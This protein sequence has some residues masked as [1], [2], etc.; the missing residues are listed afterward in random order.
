MRRP[1]SDFA[2]NLSEQ[3]YRKYKAISYSTIK[4]YLTR[5]PNS[6]I[7][8][9]IE[10][11]ESMA[12]GKLE[13][14]LLT[15]RS[16][17]D[18]LYFI[19]NIPSVSPKVLE[20]F[21]LAE[22][23]NIDLNNINDTNLNTLLI[24]A[25]YYN[26]YKLETKINKFKEDSSELLGIKT[27]AGNKTVVTTD[28]F[29]DAENL[30]KSITTA[31]FADIY[32][33]ELGDDIE[34]FHQIQFATFFNEIQVK[35]MFDK[36]IVDHTKKH[37]IPIDF[38][39]T[40]DLEIDFIRS[41]YKYKYYIQA[42]LY[43]YILS[44]ILDEDEYYADFTVSPFTFIVGNKITLCPLAWEYPIEATHTDWMMAVKD[45][46]TNFKTGQFKYYPSVLD[47]KAILQLNINDKPRIF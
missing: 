47:N 9:P 6:L 12:F 41:V 31:P 40:S 30:Y 15:K 45:I 35:C 38:K 11:T 25:E 14:T 8:A 42:E 33:P 3:E 37:I 2:L 20:V 18:E 22:K 19:A 10:E 39:V 26:N 4:S 5:G 7:S 28:D 17:L 34:V 21:K 16:S 23:E 44:N 1:L 43:R 32:F 27:K 13:D 29:M 24:L 36:I 46:D